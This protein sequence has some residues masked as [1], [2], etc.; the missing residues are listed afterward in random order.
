MDYTNH[1]VY[2][3]CGTWGMVCV[4]IWNAGIYY[5]VGNQETKMY[6]WIPLPLLASI[7]A[8]MTSS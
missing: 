8:A 5:C 2:G 7:F 6:M 3:V 4:W 1:R